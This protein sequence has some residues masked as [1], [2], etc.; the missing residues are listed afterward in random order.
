M[1]EQGMVLG[2]DLQII[3][4]SPGF[5]SGLVIDETRRLS[6]YPYGAYEQDDATQYNYACPNV[7]HDDS[8]WNIR[9]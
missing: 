9:I 5:R 2:Q 1:P 4:Q 8:D 3:K 6:M 7:F